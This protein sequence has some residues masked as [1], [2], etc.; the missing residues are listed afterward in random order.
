MKK[1]YSF[2]DKYKKYETINKRKKKSFQFEDKKL[3]Y[4]QN[5]PNNINIFVIISVIIILV[6]NL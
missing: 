5:K 4:T 6:I 1:F 3:K 2:N